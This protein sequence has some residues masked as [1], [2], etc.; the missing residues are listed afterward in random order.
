MWFLRKSR[1]STTSTLLFLVLVVVSLYLTFYNNDFPTSFITKIHQNI[2]QKPVSTHYLNVRLNLTSNTAICHS[3]D[4]LIVYVLSTAHNFDR[5]HIIRATWGTPLVGTCFVFVLGKSDDVIQQRID[6]EKRQY[7]DIVQIEHPESYA[8]VIYKEVAALHWAAHFYPSIPL[9]FKTDDDL[10]LDSLLVSSIAQTLTNY[11]VNASA[12]LLKHRPKL[13]RELASIDRSELF[14]GGWSMGYQPT[15]RSGKFG[16]SEN[17]WPHATLPQYCS[18]FGWFMSK[19]VRDRLVSA[20]YTY[21]VNKTAWIGDVFVSGFLAKAAKVS[22]MGIELDYDQTFSGKCGCSMTQRPMLTVCSS[23]LHA[24]GGGNETAKFHEY[25]SA[26]RAI[27][28]RHKNID[29]AN[30]TGMNIC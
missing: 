21:P 16:V 26:W 24:G 19:D 25:E 18:G 20:S 3:D 23:T 12:Y 10:I 8:N 11:R 28:E 13:V 4:I 17:V 30:F 22:C 7:K 5:R 1:P 27:Q 15:L 2:S 9:L 6:K 29:N 14:R